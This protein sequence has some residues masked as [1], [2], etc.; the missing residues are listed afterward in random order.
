MHNQ[1]AVSPSR[2][3][4]IVPIEPVDRAPTF[5]DIFKGLPTDAYAAG[6][7]IFWEGDEAGHIF[8]VLAGVLRI[9]KILADGRRAIV[10]FIYPGDVLGV[11]FQSRYLF[12]AE[13]VTAVKVRRFSRSRFFALVG[14]SPLLRP[15]LFAILCDEMSAAQDQMLLLGRM[16][17]QE[18]VASF[19]LA[20]HRKNGCGGTLELPMSRLDI[21]DYLGL[22]I[23]TVSRM[24]TSLGRRGF[25]AATGRHTIALRRIDALREIAG[26]DDE[27]DGVPRGVVPARR[28]VWP[29]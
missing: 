17:A 1:T 4:A 15:Q 10:G 25:I 6:E 24:M 29:N 16:S 11:S 22:T 20:V 13:A 28:A 2:G 7:A 21:A 27:R 8:D 19:L 26:A 18:R 23:E 5:R 9:Y 12:T 3:A 14:E